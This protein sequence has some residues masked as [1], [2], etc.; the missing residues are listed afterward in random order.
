MHDVLFTQIL[1]HYELLRGQVLTSGGQENRSIKN[2]NNNNRSIE[3]YHR[4]GLNTKQQGLS[5]K[6]NCLY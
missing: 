4:G 1:S 6:L 5:D 3:Q 2:N